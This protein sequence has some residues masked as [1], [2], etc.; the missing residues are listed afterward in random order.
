MVDLLLPV[1]LESGDRNAYVG[2][3]GCADDGF[4]PALGKHGCQYPDEGGLAGEIEMASLLATRL[5]PIVCHRLVEGVQGA[6]LDTVCLFVV[7]ADLDKVAC[8]ILVIFRLEVVLARI[9]MPC[10][11]AAECHPPRCAV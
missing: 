1:L 8:E 10:A 9:F 3:V 4:E 11:T 7:F 2:L 5:V 6:E